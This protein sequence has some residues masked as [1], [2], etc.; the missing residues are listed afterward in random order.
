MPEEQSFEE[1]NSLA[2][3]ALEAERIASRHPQKHHE[4]MTA[5][6]DLREYPNADF[7]FKLVAKVNG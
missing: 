4:P 2:D 6:I 3:F 1:S 5:S 7:Y